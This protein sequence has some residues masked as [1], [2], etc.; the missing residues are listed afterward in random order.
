VTI[1][2]ARD[3]RNWSG[4]YLHMWRA[5]QAQGCEIDIV[6]NLVHG[7]SIARRLRKLGAKL[8]GRRHL[9][10]WDRTTARQYSEDV[11]RRVE[12][13]DADVVF[14]PTPV[15]LAYLTLDRPVAMWT[16][17]GFV[18]LRTAYDEFDPRGISRWAA[19]DGEEI[20]RRVAT[21]G[22]LQVF[23]SEWGAKVNAEVFGNRGGSKPHVIPYGANFECEPCPTA[24]SD[25]RASSTLRLLFVGVDWSRKGA[26]KACAVA[27]DLKKRGHPVSLHIVGCTPPN[28]V[29]LGDEVVIEGFIS[30]ATS[31]GRAKLDTL[32]RQSHFLIVPTMAEAYGLVFAEASAYGLPSLS[33][34]IGGVPTIVRDGVNGQLFD[35]DVPV[36]RWADWIEENYDAERY[37]LLAEASRQLYETRLNWR[38]A[39][40]AMKS[41]LDSTK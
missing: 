27:A 4:T 36:G 41:L 1:F 22:T 12:A 15:P 21:N 38:V 9:H 37:C 32:Y 8:T 29:T 19:H 23:A 40:A 11:Q 17:A 35:F 18:A 6:D 10:F 2:D 31:E 7:R 34:R 14:S 3:V 26:D 20:D 33:H 16:D 13:T 28:G 25:R 30:K 5:L 39:G 24:L